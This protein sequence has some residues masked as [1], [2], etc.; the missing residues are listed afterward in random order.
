[1]SGSGSPANGK[2]APAPSPSHEK[3]MARNSSVNGAPQVPPRPPHSTAAARAGIRASLVGP[4]TFPASIA[5]AATCTTDSSA[6]GANPHRS[7][8][9]PTADGARTPDTAL[10]GL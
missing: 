4:A 7:E 9:V 2:N 3:A 6:Y 8:R 10:L 1:M 5:R